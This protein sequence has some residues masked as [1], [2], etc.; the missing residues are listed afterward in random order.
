MLAGSNPYA[1]TR[2]PRVDAAACRKAQGRSPV[3]D[4]DCAVNNPHGSM[5]G[6]CGLQGPS[7]IQQD[8]INSDDGKLVM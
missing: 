2:V 3:V 7:H 6:M 1:R 5:A 8:G 4:S